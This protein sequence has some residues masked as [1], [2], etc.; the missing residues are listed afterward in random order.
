MPRPNIAAMLKMLVASTALAAL[1]A[2]LSAQTIET[3][4]VGSATLQNVP[5]IPAEVRDAVQRY[6]N[7]RAALFEDWLPDGSMLAS[8]PNPAGA[9]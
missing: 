8:G 5:A 2:P 1:V 7:S 6:Q 9:T 3:R 4:Q